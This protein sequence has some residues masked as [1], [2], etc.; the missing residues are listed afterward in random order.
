MFD[1]KFEVFDDA[2]DFVARTRPIF[3]EKHDFSAKLFKNKETDEP[4]FS[5][6]SR[7]EHRFD[8]YKIAGGVLIFFVW[9]CS[10]RIWFGIRRARKKR[11]KEL[12]RAA[13]ARKKA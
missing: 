2:R 10:M 3:V 8:L 9:L 6:A 5:I 11:K 4:S 12:R 13:K 7:G 1:G